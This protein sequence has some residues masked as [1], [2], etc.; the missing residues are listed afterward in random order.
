MDRIK[1]SLCMKVYKW[2]RLASDNCF[3]LLLPSTPCEL[4]IVT[5][6]LTSVEAWVAVVMVVG[7]AAG[8]RGPLDLR[9]LGYFLEPA[10]HHIWKPLWIKTLEVIYQCSNETGI[11]VSAE[12]EHSAPK[13]FRIFGRIRIFGKCS[14]LAEYSVIW[15]NSLY[16]A[17]Y[18]ATL[19]RII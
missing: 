11:S 17:E 3:H 9:H 18:L 16:S 13:F 4:S 8:L 14:F 7:N 2:T 19:G 10:L 12:Y 1:K 5:L 15:P 6:M